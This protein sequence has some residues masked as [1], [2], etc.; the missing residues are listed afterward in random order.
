MCYNREEFNN[1]RAYLW[2][3]DH[4]LS[5]FDTDEGDYLAECGIKFKTYAQRDE[6]D[7]LYHPGFIRKHV[8]SNGPYRSTIIQCPPDGFV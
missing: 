2:A 5:D 4:C 1:W 8:V 6:H 3:L 7:S